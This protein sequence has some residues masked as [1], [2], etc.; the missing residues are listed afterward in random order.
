M[1]IWTVYLGGWGAALAAPL[2]FLSFFFFFV[3][4]YSLVKEVVMVIFF[5]AA[6]VAAYLVWEEWY[7]A[8]IKHWAKLNPHAKACD[9]LSQEGWKVGRAIQKN[10]VYTT[11]NDVHQTQR[12]Q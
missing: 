1:E 9:F 5:V 12:V 3:L 6:F 8:Q 10:I 7:R 4:V 11:F 2:F